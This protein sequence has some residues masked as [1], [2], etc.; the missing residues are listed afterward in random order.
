MLK[1]VQRHAR[2]VKV[3]GRWCEELNTRGRWLRH[4]M[5]RVEKILKKK[6]AFRE[7]LYNTKQRKEIQQI[8]V[9]PCD[10]A[11]LNFGH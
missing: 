10:P 3:G 8:N 5:Q 7:Q 2:V 6:D 9:F 1:P 11:H 4:C